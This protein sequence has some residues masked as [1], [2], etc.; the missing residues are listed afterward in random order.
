V[1][2]RKGDDRIKSLSDLR[3]KE[4]LVMQ[5]DTAHEYALRQRLTDRLI[6]TASYE[7][8]MRLLAAGRHDAVLVQRLVGLLLLKRLQLDGVVPVEMAQETDIRPTADPLQGFEQKFCFAVTEGNHQ[9]QALLNEGLAIVYADGTYES[10]YHRWFA[11]VLP[12]PEPTLEDMFHDLAMI[13]VPLL[14]VMGLGGYW[15]LRREIRRKT[16]IISQ[17]QQRFKNFMDS[18]TDGFLLYD[19]QLRLCEMNDQAIDLLPFRAEKGQLLGSMIGDAGNDSALARAVR[20]VTETGDP[21]SLE[22]S[23]SSPER[24]P[25][26]VALTMFRVPEGVGVILRDITERR[27]N[28]EKLRR[29][30]EDIRLLLEH[31]VEAIYG[32]DLE[33]RCTFANPACVGMLGYD[34]SD[35]LVGAN[36]HQLIHHS[37]AD[38]TAYPQEACLLEK[39]V[40]DRKSVHCDSEVFWRANGSAFPVEY[41][42][43][44]I[45]HGEQVRGWV[46]T[47]VDIS[48]RLQAEEEKRQ[49]ES[50]LH[51]SFKMEAIGTLAGGIAHDFNNILGAIIGYTEI[52]KEEA[53]PASVVTAHLQEVLK[54]GQRARDLIKRILAFSRQTADSEYHYLRPAV[55]IQEVEKMLRPSIPT[56]IAIR[57]RLVQTGLYIYADPTQIHQILMNL[58]TNAYHAM[59][60]SGGTMDIEL[61]ETDLSADE[62]AHEPGLAAGRFFR[63][64]VRDTGQGIHPDL[65]GRIFDPFFTTK[66]VGK[67]TGMG[68][69]MVHG[70]VRNH[71]GCI[72]VESRPGEGAAFH[73]FLPAV[74]PQRVPEDAVEERLPGGSERVL[75]VDDETMLVEMGRDML[76]RLGYR[77]TAVNSSLEALEIFRRAPGDFDLVISDQTMPGMTGDELARQI[78]RIRPDMPVIVCTGYSSV[79]SENK[80][81]AIGV[82]ELLLKPILK[83]DLSLVI[84]RVLDDGGLLKSEM[85]N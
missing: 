20:L 44:P 65:Q 83:K 84:R 80:V 39:V 35:Q 24:G 13:I 15:F 22:E 63:I 4:V 57:L 33:G 38:G 2:V 40:R 52:A 48:R 7:E 67:G 60:G 85:R 79:L 28:V 64:T 29:Q 43:H 81:R 51:Q 23:F 66:E 62:V 8:A 54:A 10:L 77:V 26:H 72:T 82:R 71:G 55:I 18:A 3:G 32:C 30:E 47:F 56:S 50:K 76:S 61:A 31:T 34:R 16:A 19:D 5:G 6:T 45:Y 1:F 46:V 58:G 49:L 12:P 37:F 73:V 75:F 42:A 9:L 27:I 70:I 53:D 36:M 69:A 78:L 25:H 41:W 14:L 74:E 68:L 21:C 17:S 59:E 11:P